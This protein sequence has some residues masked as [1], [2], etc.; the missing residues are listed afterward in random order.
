MTTA[1]RFDS[2]GGRGSGHPEIDRRY[3]ELAEGTRVGRFRVG[4]EIG[5]G[6]FA[7]VYRAIDSWLGR[8]VALKVVARPGGA[9]RERPVG[10]REAA[11]LSRVHSPHVVTMFDLVRHDE[12]DVMV[13]EL[14]T[15]PT[16]DAIC[17]DGP[18]GS[19]DVRRLG[20]QL[21]DGLD[22]LH[23][24]RIVHGDIKPANLGLA[25]SG[26]LKVLDLGVA[27]SLSS[28]ASDAG[29]PC[30]VVAGTPAYMAPERLRGGCGDERS[31]IWSAGAV[32]FEL[33]TGRCAVDSLSASSRDAFIREGIFPDP[34]LLTRAIAGPLRDVVS[35]A[36]EPDPRRRLHSARAL[37][38]ALADESA[39]R[40]QDSRPVGMGYLRRLVDGFQVPR[41]A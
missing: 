17:R 37:R 40:T 12:A 41:T 33:A 14:V 6:S 36:M 9:D 8:E 2:G 13:L 5:R 16:L 31:D 4:P 30:R 28:G 23:G 3:V 27:R 34:Q 35:A 20:E 15:G 24:A 26:L 11:L 21:A 22:V 29:P 18:L 38:L 39:R 7:V 32:L 1:T 25:G 19:D 10:M